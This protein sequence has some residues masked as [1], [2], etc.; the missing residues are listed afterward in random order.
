MVDTGTN[1]QH[2]GPS[3]DVLSGVRRLNAAVDLDTDFDRRRQSS[4]SNHSYSLE[5][6]GGRGITAKAERNGH[7]IYQVHL[8]HEVVRQIVQGR[9]TF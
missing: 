3:L 8:C 9:L 6:I 5:G 1:S 7:K 2:I 4:L